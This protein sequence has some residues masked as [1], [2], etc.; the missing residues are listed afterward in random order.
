MKPLPWR[1]M[2]KISIQKD[3]HVSL[4]KVFEE[5]STVAF[6]NSFRLYIFELLI[7]NKLDPDP[8]SQSTESPDPDPDPNTK[9]N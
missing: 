4:G 6:K 2:M 1:P 9:F 3:Q 5:I 8:E 7:I